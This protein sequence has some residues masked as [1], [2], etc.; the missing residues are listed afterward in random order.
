MAVATAAGAAVQ[1]LAEKDGGTMGG[2]MGC[3][4][5]SGSALPTEPGRALEPA[6]AIMVAID[7]LLLPVPMR[8]MMRIATATQE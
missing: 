5:A 6:T 7:D 8:I 1:Q 2:T 3:L 4:A